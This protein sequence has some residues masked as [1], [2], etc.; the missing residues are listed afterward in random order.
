VL[1][2]RT[3]R[4]R[5]SLLAIAVAAASVA[6]LGTAFVLVLQARLEASARNVLQARVD[7]A[8]ADVRFDGTGQV[9]RTEGP[10][11]GA[12]VF[13]GDRLVARASGGAEVERSVTKLAGHE[14][15]LHGPDDT[16]LYAEPLIRE[17][18]PIGTV[19]GVLSLDANRDAI[20]IVQLGVVGLGLVL[21]LGTFLAAQLLVGR[22]LEPVVRLTAQAGQWSASDVDRRFGSDPSMAAELAE[23]AATLDGMLDRLSAVLRH[24]QRLSAELSHEL[25]TPLSRIVAEVD[26]LQARERSPE[27]VAAALAVVAAS[28]DRMQSILQTLLAAARSGTA[29]PPGRAEALAVV[30]ALLAS[31]DDPRL[32]AHG[33][34]QA[35]GVG[36]QV[37]ERI[38][39]PLLDNARRYT[40]ARVV[41]TV[42]SGPVIEV[43]DD[44]PGVADGLAEAVF[45][46]G[47]RGDP[48]DGHD[49]AGLGLTLSR[50]LARA[51]GGD[52]TLRGSTATVRLPG[53]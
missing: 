20:D 40:V 34:E 17:G 43:A 21:M 37:L 42:S 28:A 31:Y 36:A 25:R 48:E 51:A 8:A 16:L 33:S 18:R 38:L 22:S 10:A 9:V 13:L 30:T 44:G 6:V 26:L 47:T 27:E 2:P 39:A 24:E 3:L 52:V 29:V 5:F 41:V 4:G 19:V 35:V 50:R 45:D 14:G 49:G 7:A 12:W 32:S 46:P 11:E 15:F 53:G 1:R 23:L